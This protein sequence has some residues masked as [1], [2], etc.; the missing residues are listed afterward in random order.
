MNA[1][2]K[3]IQI[4]VF[5]NFFQ[6]NEY[7]VWILCISLISF[8]SIADFGL[9][10]YLSNHL[11]KNKLDIK[12]FNNFIEIISFAKKI[13]NFSIIFLLITIISLFLF[14]DVHILFNLKEENK[15]IFL[16]LILILSIG[17]SFQLLS[18]FYFSI[19]R[20][21]NLMHK[22]IYIN[23]VYLLLQII[24]FTAFSIFYSNIYLTVLIFVLPYFF[25]FLNLKFY[26]KKIIVNFEF[27]KIK[28]NKEKISIIF[29]SLSFLLILLSHNFLN[30]IPVY[31]LQ[32]NNIDSQLIDFF[33]YKS[34]ILFLMQ[35]SNSL[36]YSYSPSLNSVFFYDVKNFKSILFKLL[37]TVVT[38]MIIFIVFS[39]I[40]GN[41]LFDIWTGNNVNFK[42][43]IF[44]IFYL[45]VVFRI[46][47]NFFISIFESLNKVIIVSIFYLT[48]NFIFLFYLLS[49]NFNNISNNII[50][51]NL[52]FPEFI[53]S[54]I[55][56]LLF[57][58]NFKK[59]LSK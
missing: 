18:S 20:S 29:G 23:C 27:I 22:A 16:F 26:L 59:H 19:L 15:N 25:L 46:I 51:I 53:L 3:F 38:T 11:L 45:F 7:S 47:N 9:S 30:F 31:I 17:S 6:S 35:I 54:I 56:T 41:F 50:Y 40:F 55:L 43:D 57:I 10:T 12:N 8:Y 5:T 1:I 37:L 2:F 44:L 13:I 48:F 4:F 21:I 33:V 52:L 49:I 58:F 14:F 24:I 36:F 28:F 34:Y 39:L 32:K 42:L